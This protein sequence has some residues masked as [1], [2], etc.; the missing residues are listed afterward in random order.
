MV[1]SV[2]DEIGTDI[3]FQEKVRFYMMNERKS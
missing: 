3:Y 2:M 1:E